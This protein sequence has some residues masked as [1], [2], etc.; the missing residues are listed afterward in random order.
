[1]KE[2]ERAKK[3]K[4]K[5]EKRK[6]ECRH[7]KTLFLSL[8][9]LTPVPSLSLF[10]FPVLIAIDSVNSLYSPSLG[11]GDPDDR[12]LRPKLISPEKLTA[13]RCFRDF[14][15][16]QLVRREAREG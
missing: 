1:V 16:H 9:R 6:M 12:T 2:H 14:K 8:T 11:F 10:R 5:K 15:N 7:R 13:A 3:R 4:K